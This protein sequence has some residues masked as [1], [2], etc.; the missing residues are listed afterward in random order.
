VRVSGRGAVAMP[1]AQ[2]SPT[3]RLGEFFIFVAFIKIPGGAM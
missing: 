2:M 3:T 1:K